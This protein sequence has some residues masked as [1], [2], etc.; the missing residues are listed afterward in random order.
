LYPR[1]L[2]WNRRW[3]V[4]LRLRLSLLHG[5]RLERPVL[6]RRLDARLLLRNRRRLYGLGLSLLHGRR[7]KRPV[8]LRLYARLLLW[9]RRGLH[10]LRLT[11]LNRRRCK[12][13]VLRR[14]NWGWPIRLQRLNLLLLR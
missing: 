1:L 5:R 7:L 11:L 13:P 12:W 2:L 8:L 6:R 3:P 14:R 9:N 10:R 4:R